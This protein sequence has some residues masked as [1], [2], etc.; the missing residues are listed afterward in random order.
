MPIMAMSCSLVASLM[1]S[2]GMPIFRTVSYG[3][4]VLSA[5]WAAASRA[6]FPAAFENIMAESP[7]TSPN[8]LAAEI[9]TT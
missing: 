3:M 2:H 8:F 6:I 1:T 5:R 9:S 4:P 7:S